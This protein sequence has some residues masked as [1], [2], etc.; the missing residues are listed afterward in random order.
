MVLPAFTE[1]SSAS[2]ISTALTPSCAVTTFG[3]M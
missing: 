2:Q 1:R 3:T